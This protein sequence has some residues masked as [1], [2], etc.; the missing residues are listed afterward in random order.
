MYSMAIRTIHLVTSVN[1]KPEIPF[2][3]LYIEPPKMTAF[4]LFGT[5]KEE[6]IYQVGYEYAKE[7]LRNYPAF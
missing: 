4:S 5:E 3:D 6:E 1:I 7:L 2:C